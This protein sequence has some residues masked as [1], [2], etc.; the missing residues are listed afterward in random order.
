MVERTFVNY[1]QVVGVEER[2]Y[3][4]EMQYGYKITSVHS[5]HPD[6]STHHEIIL[7][8]QP[9][10]QRIALLIRVCTLQYIHLLRFSSLRFCQT[11]YIWFNKT[12]AINLYLIH[13]IHSIYHR[14]R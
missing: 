5:R 6:I 9:T 8:A 2:P 3:S 4:T 13:T 1:S 14:S 11:V 7:A 12:T 10:A